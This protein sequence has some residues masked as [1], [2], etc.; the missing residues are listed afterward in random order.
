MTLGDWL[1][2]LGYDTAA[3]G[4]MH[5]NGAAKHGFA[6]RLDAPDWTRW[7]REH[8]PAGGDRRRRWRPGS[9][10]PPSG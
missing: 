1:G 8:P 2:G 5:F 3:F 4:K 6:D 7:L 9:T 10:R